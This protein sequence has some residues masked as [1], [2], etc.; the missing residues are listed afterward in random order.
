MQLKSQNKGQRASLPLLEDSMPHSEEYYKILSD[1]QEWPDWK[2]QAYNDCIATSAHANKPKI[3]VTSEEA[4]ESW[5]EMSKKIAEAT[6]S[7]KAL[8]EAFE[9]IENKKEN[10]QMKFIIGNRGSGVTTDILLEASKFNRPIIVPMEPDKVYI[11]DKCVDLGIPCPNVYTFKQVKDGILSGQKACI[12]HI[13]DVNAYLEWSLKQYGFEG[14][15]GTVS[16]SLE[17][18][19]E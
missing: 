9:N 12:V 6:A 2:I 4:I 19:F 5:S 16:A 10:R 15:I 17:A 8:G 13:S 11:K 1:M 14:R 7:I 3:K 18:Q